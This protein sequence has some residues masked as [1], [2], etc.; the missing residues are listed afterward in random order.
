MQLRLSMASDSISECNGELQGTKSPSLVRDPAGCTITFSANDGSEVTVSRRQRLEPE[1]LGPHPFKHG[2]VYVL[3]SELIS[4]HTWDVFRE[5]EDEGTGRGQG[6]PETGVKSVNLG[7][8]T[9]GRN[10]SERIQTAVQYGTTYLTE[11]VNKFQKKNHLKALADL[12]RRW[13]AI[14]ESALKGADHVGG[15]TL[16]PFASKTPPHCIYSPW[17]HGYMLHALKS[18]GNPR[19]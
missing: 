13:G 9:L 1:W 10:G 16:T 11:K 17:Y 5:I 14:T 18:C 2:I 19:I 8:C 7:D 4:H 12:V 15:T 6:S 3:V